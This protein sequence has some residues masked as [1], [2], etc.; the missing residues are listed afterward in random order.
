MKE[1]L[2]S[3]VST[4]LNEWNPLGE[5]AELTPDLEGYKY[6]AMDILSEIKITKVSTEQA[7]SDVLTQ[8]FHITLDEAKLKYYSRKIEQLLNVQ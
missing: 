1:E 7:V 6:E 2:I 8:A 4:I 3:S 5:N